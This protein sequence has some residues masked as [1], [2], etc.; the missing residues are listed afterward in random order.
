MLLFRFGTII[1]VSVTGMIVCEEER[2]NKRQQEEN[3]EAL[4]YWFMPHE[5][6]ILG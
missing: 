3:N 1:I 6:P 4:I 2:E 5:A